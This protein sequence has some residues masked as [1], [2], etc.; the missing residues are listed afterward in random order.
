[1]LSRPP[2]P[3]PV[4]GSVTY[5]RALAGELPPDADPGGIGEVEAYYESH[6][7]EHGVP[8]HVVDLASAGFRPVGVRVAM[9]E[10]E[11]RRLTYYS[12]GEHRIVCDYRY[13]RQFPG[14]LPEGGR[15]VFFRR[16]GLTFCVTRLG[17]E[18]CILATTMPLEAL[19]ARL[20]GWT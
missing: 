6:E 16:D 3:G 10:G 11:P 14:R 12:D 19:A 8:T 7:S 1:M 18:V 17:D 5:L 4:A 15:P 2:A 13:V 20:L 9:A